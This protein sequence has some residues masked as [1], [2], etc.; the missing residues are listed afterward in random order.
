M[1]NL[2]DLMMVPSLIKN[3]MLTERNS[4]GFYRREVLPPL[5]RPQIVNVDSDFVIKWKI[6]TIELEDEDP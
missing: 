3:P 2:H 5:S 1:G 4:L 6:R